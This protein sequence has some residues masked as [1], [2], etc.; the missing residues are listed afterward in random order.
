MVTILY[1]MWWAAQSWYERVKS[2]TIIKYIWKS[3]L[4][5]RPIVKEPEE[6]LPDI[7][8]LYNH[9]VIVKRIQDRMSLQDFLNSVNEDGF[10][11]DQLV[12]LEELI[13]SILRIETVLIKRMERILK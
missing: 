13:R 3:T 5:T 6:P 11:M 12:T 4:I 8:A 10:C 2:T 1:V 7:L 9:P